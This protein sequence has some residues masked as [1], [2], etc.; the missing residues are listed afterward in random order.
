TMDTLLD[1]LGTQ[2]FAR[3]DD[4]VD[5]LHAQNPELS[6]DALQIR[7]WG[8]KLLRADRAADAVRVFGLGL[9]LYPERFDFL[10]DGIGQACE[11]AG[12][13]EEA[14]AHYRH[15]LALEPG[16]AHARARLAALGVASQ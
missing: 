3:I 1:Q 5:Q 16:Q 14:I 10:Y 13:R 6:L 15:A 11:A 2:G 12:R 7:D 9:H 4:L 8:F